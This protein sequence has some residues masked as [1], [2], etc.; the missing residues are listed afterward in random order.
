M[1]FGGNNE[2]SVVSNCTFEGNSAVDDGG[3]GAFTYGN[4]GLIIEHSTFLR[5]HA[6]GE[7][8]FVR[9]CA[10]NVVCHAA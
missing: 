2:D 9:G 4:T 10:L 5:N 3:G 6:G 1:V 8:G 7:G